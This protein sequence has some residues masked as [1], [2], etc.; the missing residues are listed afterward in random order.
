MCVSSALNFE[1]ADKFLQ[2]LYEEYE[3][4]RHTKSILPNF[5]H[6]EFATWRTQTSEKKL[7]ESKL[8]FGPKIQ[9]VKISLI[10]IRNNNISVGG[11]IY[12]DFGFMGSSSYTDE[13]RFQ[14]L[15]L[16]T[17]VGSL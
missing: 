12:L 9:L 16:V 7:T 5:L 6:S 8:K 4:S 14:S 2:T 11:R 17:G 3:I 13:Y 10:I 1:V 15:C